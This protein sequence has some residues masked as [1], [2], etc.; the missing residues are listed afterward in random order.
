VGRLSGRQ[1][2]ESIA[3]QPGFPARRPAG[4]LVR[5]SEAVAATSIID[6]K[7][8][9]ASFQTFAKQFAQY[10]TQLGQ[11][12]A[13]WNAATGAINASATAVGGV[14]A[15]LQKSNSLIQSLLGSLKFAYAWFAF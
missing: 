9:A 2:R 15:N 6:I 13:Q 4:R 7:V 11:T 8:V 10:T 14:A 5:G 1:T 3:S 12:P